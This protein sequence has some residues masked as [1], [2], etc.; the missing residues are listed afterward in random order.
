MENVR[1]TFIRTADQVRGK[2]GGVKWG[3]Y[4][5]SMAQRFPVFVGST[6]SDL[7]SYRDAVR[8]TLHRME[9][10]VRG[11]EYFGSLPETPKDECLRIVRSCRA[12][13]GI[14]AMRYG[15]IDPMTGQSLAHLEYEEA[16]RIRLPSLIYLID[17]DR[18][19]ILPRYVEFGEGAEK[20]RIL[21]EV[22][23]KRHVI[24]VFTTPEDLSAKVAHDLTE[25]ANRD[26]FEVR[27]GELSR[28]VASL[29]RIDW[30]DD[31]QYAF[32]KNKLGDAAAQFP[33]DAVLR[34]VIEFILSNDRLAAT[35]LIART[36]SLDIRNAIDLLMKVD[37]GIKAVVEC[38][39]RALKNKQG[40]T[41]SG[42]RPE[43]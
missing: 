10:V 20:L 30:L 39:R 42:R 7:Q 32:L 3:V 26:G 40:E 22:L 41:R 2:V 21:K 35:F 4:N 34:E 6:F 31:S 5:P 13:I 16:Q 17:E 14:F 43:K 28:I 27:E 33:S 29:P 19:P 36:T 15:S 23:R 8:H 12:Y 38:G 37:S 18:Q 1:F 24:S 9:A 25:L 11:M